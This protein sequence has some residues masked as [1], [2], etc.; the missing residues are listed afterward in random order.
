MHEA[1]ALLTIGFLLIVGIYIQVAILF[2]VYTPELFPTEGGALTASATPSGGRRRSSR[3]LSCSRCSG[4]TALRA[5]W[6]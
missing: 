6:H 4:I 5:C 3:H 1:S 2:G